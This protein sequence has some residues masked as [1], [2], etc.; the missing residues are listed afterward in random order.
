MSRYICFTNLNILYFETEGVIRK[1]KIQGPTKTYHSQASSF[2]SLSSSRIDHPL[3]CLPA[4]GGEG[5]PLPCLPAV[6]E[7]TF[8]S[9]ESLPLQ[10]VPPLP[11][12][13]TAAAMTCPY[14][15]A[16]IPLRRRHAPALCVALDILWRAGGSQ[17]W[18]AAGG[19]VTLSKASTEVEADARTSS[20]PDPR[21]RPAR[22]LEDCRTSASF[23]R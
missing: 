12:V 13:L 10:R 16:A 7:R 17:A 14:P 5:R 6:G 8:P 4:A 19:Q 11:C 3:H 23:P 20:P 18:D 2:F 9:P 1:D 22:V 21:T 15:A